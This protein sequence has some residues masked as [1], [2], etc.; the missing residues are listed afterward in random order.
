[1]SDG[2]LIVLSTYLQL[3]PKWFVS[4]S[5]LVAGHVAQEKSYRVALA[6]S[7]MASLSLEMVWTWFRPDAPSH[8]AAGAC[9]VG[10]TVAGAAAAGLAFGAE[11]SPALTF[12]LLTAAGCLSIPVNLLAALWRIEQK[13]SA[14]RYRIAGWIISVSLGS[15][16]ASCDGDDFREIL[17]GKRNRCRHAW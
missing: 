13:T 7:L 16:S 15:P 9:L 3:A 12:A 5:L 2:H 8:R 17:T 6:S 14:A 4:S 1:M 11:P 10:S